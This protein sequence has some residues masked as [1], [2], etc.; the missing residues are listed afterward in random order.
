MSNQSE[1]NTVMGNRSYSIES[2]VNGLGSNVSLSKL[3][4]KTLVLPPEIKSATDKANIHYT[5]VR[6]LEEF[7]YAYGMISEAESF[8]RNWPMFAGRFRNDKQ[9][10]LLLM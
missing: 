10:W 2:L 7:A 1:L 5:G 9:A 3:L 6:G 4:K 8:V